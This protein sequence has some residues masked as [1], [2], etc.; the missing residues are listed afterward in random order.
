MGN[1]HVFRRHRSLVQSAL[2]IR[3]NDPGTTSPSS[4]QSSSATVLIQSVSRQSVSP[5]CP[6]IQLRTR[7]WDWHWEFSGEQDGHGPCP[8][9]TYWVGD[10][11]VKDV[12][13]CT[14][15]RGQWPWLMGWGYQP[16]TDGCVYDQGTVP[17]YNAAI[18]GPVWGKSERASQEPWSGWRW[19]A[20]W[21]GTCRCPINTLIKK[22]LTSSTLFIKW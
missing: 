18:M 11:S 8:C 6:I 13:V 17:C 22:D 12:M 4:P 10:V 19:G 20:V 15:M 21:E 16:F 3:W 2:W 1:Y 5:H 7:L 14:K 9:E